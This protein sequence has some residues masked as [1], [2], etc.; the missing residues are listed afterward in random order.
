MRYLARSLAWQNYNELGAEAAAYLA[1]V[2]KVNAVLTTLQCAA[3]RRT[4]HAP[5]TCQQR[6]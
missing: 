2:L 4:P 6:R 3:A 1:E 5:H